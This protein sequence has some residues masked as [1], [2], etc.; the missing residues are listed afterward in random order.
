MA[1]PTGAGPPAV[2]SRTPVLLLSTIRSY[3]LMVTPRRAFLKSSAEEGSEGWSFS[4]I[5]YGV[6]Q[7]P[8]YPYDHIS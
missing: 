7:L 1:R 2:P 3:A 8:P 5:R 4:M 6:N